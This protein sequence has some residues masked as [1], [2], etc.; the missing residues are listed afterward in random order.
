MKDEGFNTLVAGRQN[1]MNPLFSSGPCPPWSTR[2]RALATKCDT[3]IH[4]DLI[5]S[6][7][8]RDG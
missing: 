8:S 5:R 1:E 6:R 4:Q 3:K 2:R 7:N